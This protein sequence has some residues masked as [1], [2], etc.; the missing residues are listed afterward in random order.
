MNKVPE[1]IVQ[2]VEFDIG[3]AGIVILMYGM[4][5]LR[6]CI[7]NYCDVKNGEVLLAN[8]I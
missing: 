5:E 2:I 6:V 1:F 7:G 4:T 8:L 3:A